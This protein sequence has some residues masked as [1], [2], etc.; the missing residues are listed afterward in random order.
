MF[1]P[2]PFFCGIH[3]THNTYK[4]ATL[5]KG[6]QGWVIETLR[7][8]SVGSQSDLMEECP[9]GSLITSAVDGRYILVRPLKV[10]LT[11]PHEIQ[12]A[13]EFQVDSLFPYKSSEG[14]YQ[15]QILETQEK[16]S[17]LSVVGVRTDH[18]QKHL[19]ELSFEPECVTSLPQ[20]LAALLYLSSKSEKLELILH[21]ES[22][23]VQI[24]L[25]QRGNLIKAHRFS[26]ATVEEL[27][28]E[29]KR[30]LF[31]F[32]QNPI[33]SVSLL[34]SFDEPS[35]SL[36]QETLGLTPQ[37]LSLSSFKISDEKLEQFA[38][39]IGIALMGAQHDSL[40]FRQKTFLYPFPMK[41][42]KRPLFAMLGAACALAISTYLLTCVWTEGKRV[43]LKKEMESIASQLETPLALE[44][45]SPGDFTSELSRLRETLEERPD[46]FPLFPGLPRVKELLPWLASLS[47]D[48]S[49]T[50][51]EISYHLEK[52]PEIKKR[53]EHYLAKVFLEMTIKDPTSAKQFQEALLKSNAFVDH[54]HP[55]TWEQQG[56]H[57]KVSFALKDK[58]RYW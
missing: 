56:A 42:L 31:A 23:S 36:I 33:E 19:K 41:R 34:G 50:F 18:L 46:T 48:P 22:E 45:S 17:S 43:S 53:S 47:N 11:K 8:V 54:K 40:N 16:Q 2:S 32:S 10:S 29:L 51:T 4:V 26:F 24:A 55:L 15:G 27:H 20:A 5:K 49:L 30:A 58:T 3:K 12:S 13:L 21:L 38:I 28:V 39:P 14:I 9:K 25:C 35:K 7:E 6:R 1:T 37:K 57:Y 52:H 44:L